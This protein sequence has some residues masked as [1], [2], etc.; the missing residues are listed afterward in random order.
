MIENAN[1]LKLASTTLKNETSPVNCD[2]VGGPDYDPSICLNSKL[3]CRAVGSLLQPR[4]FETGP[5]ELWGYENDTV[6]EELTLDNITQR[7][8]EQDLK[9]Y[10][11]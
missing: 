1:V 6:Y 2:K 8:N 9:R 4:C 3:Y 5:L 11:Y 7:V 10:T